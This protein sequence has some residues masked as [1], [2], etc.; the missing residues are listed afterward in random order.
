MF[1]LK[2]SNKIDRQII[3]IIGIGGIGMSGIALILHQ[4][5]FTVQG[6]D[7]KM[8][9]NIN[10]LI[11]LGIKISIGH[12]R[13]NVLGASYVC[14]SSAI[15]KQNVELLEAKENSIII[16]SRAELLNHIMRSKCSI[17]ISGSHGKTTTT[18]MIAHLF[19]ISNLNPTVINGGIINNKFTNKFTNAYLGTGDYIIVE[20]DES[21]DTFTKI[22]PQISV[23]TNIDHEHL[24]FYK[25]FD[26]LKEKF[27]NFITKI[28]FD[29]FSVVSI[30][31]QNIRDIIKNISNRKIIT[32]SI[33]DQNANL[34][35]KNIRFDSD[36][37]IFDMVWTYLGKSYEFIEVKINALAHHN[38]LNSLA[39]FAVGL[40]MDLNMDLNLETSVNN[41]FYQN[42]YINWS[43]V[44]RRFTE[45]CKIN[46]GMII[47]DYAHH[48]SEV[49]A[50]LEIAKIKKLN[51]NKGKLCAIVQPHRY[52]RL[53]A[54]LTEFS[55]SF[56]DADDIYIL[57]VYSANEN[58]IDDIDSNTLVNAINDYQQAS[59][60]KFIGDNSTMKEIIYKNIS[61]G[62]FYIFM[63]AGDIT[64]LAQSFSKNNK[65]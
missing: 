52:S 11:D 8:N 4:M 28:P 49:R 25:N 41:N 30:D 51:Q 12:K 65:L 10:K 32:Y 21:D 23:I 9:S 38:V 7:L 5:G 40:M 62:D 60:A 48:P 35:A 3:H 17:A 56:N 29:G 59:K 58:K 1:L 44:K 39:A 31:D 42:L 57:P 20:A 6:S 19:E 43:S 53:S 55:S 47:D 64:N 22:D 13:E 54:L 14:Y 18:S 24:N 15:S 33:K 26:Q 37:S 36:Y 46:G 61:D 50:T 16:I 27:K 45:I 2:K 63:G 34:Y